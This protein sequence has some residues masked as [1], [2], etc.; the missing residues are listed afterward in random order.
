MPDVTVPCPHCG[1]GRVALAREYLATYRALL[2]AGEASGAELAR[3]LGTKGPAMCNRLAGLERKG[4]AV[5][6]VCGR[7]RLFRAVRPRG[8]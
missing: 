8:G 3:R 7:R 2:A 6:R 5:S 4:L 1:V